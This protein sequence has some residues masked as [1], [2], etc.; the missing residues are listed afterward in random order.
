MSLT[1]SYERPISTYSPFDRLLAN[2]YDESAWLAIF[3]EA[4]LNTRICTVIIKESGRAVTRRHGESYESSI[5][6]RR[7]ALAYC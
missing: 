2:H 3:G 5:S 6:Y 1:L 4:R 7:R